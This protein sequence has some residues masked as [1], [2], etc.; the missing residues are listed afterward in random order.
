MMVQ[1]SSIRKFLGET[2]VSHELTCRVNHFLREHDR[3]QRNRTKLAEVEAFTLISMIIYEDIKI[4]AFLPILRLH[5]L[6]YHFHTLEPNAV[7]QLAAQAT[8]EVS[9]MTGEDLHGTSVS[10]TCSSSCT[11]RWSIAM[12]MR[13][14]DV[15]G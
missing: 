2:K 7:R 12:T 9:V 3:M 1:Q 15:F 8:R 6:L 14:P 10:P 5:P 13:Y 4:E 11:E